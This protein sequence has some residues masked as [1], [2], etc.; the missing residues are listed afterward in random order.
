MIGVFPRLYCAGVVPIRRA[1]AGVKD[2]T[3]AATII[4][5]EVA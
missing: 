4:S 1:L 3:L 2:I 5:G